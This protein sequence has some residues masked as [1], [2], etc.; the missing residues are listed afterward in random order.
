MILFRVNKLKIEKGK[1]KFHNFPI[2]KCYSEKINF[3]KTFF[4]LMSKLDG[5]RNNFYFN[6]NK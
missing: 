2:F 1:W 6:H 4:N 3:F 5:E